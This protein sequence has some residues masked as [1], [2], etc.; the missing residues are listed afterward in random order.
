MSA[1]AILQLLHL[2]IYPARP[3]RDQCAHSRNGLL[4]IMNLSFLNALAYQLPILL[5]IQK[6]L[7]DI[8]LAQ[9]SSKAISI[10]TYSFQL[11]PIK[12]PT[13]FAVGEIILATHSTFFFFIKSFHFI[14]ISTSVGTLPL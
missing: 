10:F 14:S 5:Y 11:M 12:Q 6:S 13:N 8:M 7:G 1:R 9:F 4:I 3:M 2:G